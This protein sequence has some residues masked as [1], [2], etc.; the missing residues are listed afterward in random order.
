M[1]PVDPNTTRKR[2]VDAAA[3]RNPAPA[4]GPAVNYPKPMCDAPNGSGKQIVDKVAY[5][6]MYPG[7]AVLDMTAFKVLVAVVVGGGGSGWFSKFL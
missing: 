6:R 7:G 2:P 4:R 3:S 1:A 5:E